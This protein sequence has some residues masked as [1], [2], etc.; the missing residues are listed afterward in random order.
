MTIAF[1]ALGGLLAWL[2]Y[3]VAD[4]AFGWV[5][6]LIWLAVLIGALIGTLLW[7]RRTT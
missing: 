6:E 2:G 4:V 7:V 3:S 1:G 5:G